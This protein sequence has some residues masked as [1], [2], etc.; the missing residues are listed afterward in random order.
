MPKVVSVLRSLCHTLHNLRL[1]NSR[2]VRLQLSLN[3]M[4]AKQHVQIDDDNFATASYQFLN[5]YFP[6]IVCILSN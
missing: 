6:C 5:T 3:V 4:Y 2:Y 1:R